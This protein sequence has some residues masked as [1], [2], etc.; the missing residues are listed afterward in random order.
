[1]KMKLTYLGHSAFVV[2]EEGFK[3]IIDP[4]LQETPYLI[5]S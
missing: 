4:I 2:E 1:M 5:L 3:A